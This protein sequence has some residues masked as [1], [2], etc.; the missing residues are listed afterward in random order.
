M[1]AIDCSTKPRAARRLTSAW[2]R[3]DCTTALSR[4]GLSGAAR[5]LVARDVDEAVERAAGDAAGDAGK[6]DLVAGAGAHAIERAAFAALP[7][8]FAG[9]RMVGADEEVVQRELVAGG[10]AQADRVPDVGPFDV[11]GAHQHGALLLH[12]V[13]IEPRRAVGLVDRAMGAEPG[14]VP[15]AGREGPDAGDPVAALAFDRLDL[16]AGTPGQHRAR[17][18]AE[19]RVRHRQIEIGRRHRAAAGLAQAP[20]GRGVGLAMVSMTW[21]KVTGSV[22]IPFDERGSSRRNSPAS[23]SLSSSAGGSRRV[24]SISSEARRDGGRT[25]SAR[26]I[27]AW[28]PARSAEVGNQRIQGQCL[29]EPLVVADRS[30]RV[31]ASSLSICSI[32]LP[33]V[34]KPR[35]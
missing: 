6:A 23:C 5:H 18:V 22:S 30:S 27:T 4:S 9:D 33:L 10:A 28:S 29:A 31:A 21:K 3:L 25:A 19:D 2:A 26:A 12:A 34:S 20:G 13:G 1:S 7:V 35:K 32:D 15:A 8:E 16:G 14:R 24:L 17:I 11:L